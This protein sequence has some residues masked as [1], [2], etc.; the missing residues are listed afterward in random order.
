M[1]WYSVAH[2]D[3]N[4][5]TNTDMIT[6]SAI[7]LRVLVSTYIRKL[8]NP[9]RFSSLFISSLLSLI[10][11]FLIAQRNMYMWEK[12]GT[13]KKQRATIMN[14]Q[15]KM[16]KET[17]RNKILIIRY[18]Q[19]TSYTHIELHTHKLAFFSLFTFFGRVGICNEFQ[20]ERERLK[21]MN[22][23]KKNLWVSGTWM[24]SKN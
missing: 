16:E 10:S 13:N 23:V 20:C 12:N 9:K 15:S 5:D 19:L 24:K 6:L 2:T 3:T 14:I 17:K 8:P 18:V 1:V 4:T 21:W 7:F 22:Q 11:R